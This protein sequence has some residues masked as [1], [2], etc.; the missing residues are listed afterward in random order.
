MTSAVDT[1][2][3]RAKNKQLHIQIQDLLLH[4]RDNQQILQRHQAF[5][6]R[7]ISSYDFRELIETLSL[8]MPEA[9]SLQT[10]TL[11]LV[12]EGYNIR[13]ILEDLEMS[14]DTFPNLLFL[15]SSD[16]ALC[17]TTQ[18]PFPDTTTLGTF[19]QTTHGKLFPTYN[20]TSIA[21]VPLKRQQNIIGYMGMGSDQ[22]ERFGP[23]LATDFI[24]RLAS[25]VAICLEN[26]INNERLKHLGLTDSL[27][28]IHNRRYI[29][30][31]LSEEIARA[32]RERT[33]LSFLYIDIDYFKHV[34]D[35]FGHQSGDVVL[36]SI[37]ACI[38]KELRLTDALGRF[39]GEEF[40]VLLSNTSLK[41]AI[42]IGER[43]RVSIS[44]QRVHL[45]KRQEV[46]SVTTSIGVA[47]IIP[48][49]Q[50]LPI[51][52]LT[53]QLI[54]QADQALYQAKSSGRNSVVSFD[55]VVQPQ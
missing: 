48:P 34:N 44:E 7:L 17:E 50:G 18:Q 4:A 51:D 41:D 45:V 32:H 31:R 25:V 26:V 12:D 5:D 20:P 21:I 37:S 10:V 33:P 15:E 16:E 30:Q 6:L 27:T 13:R 8:A 43:I 42:M 24:E 19:D 1:D 28:G 39:G 55:Q 14:L 23:H 35:Q 52:E 38:K 3:L 40:V 9:F 49:E 46:I 47:S 53:Q 22:L 36:R 29:D 54:T 2:T 11:A